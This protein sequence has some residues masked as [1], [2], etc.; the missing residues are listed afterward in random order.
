L[1][2]LEPAEA[3]AASDARFTKELSVKPGPTPPQ[4]EEFK[5]EP[6]QVERGSSHQLT[7]TSNVCARKTFGAAANVIDDPQGLKDKHGL[8]ITKPQVL[9]NGCKFAADL[10]VSDSAA[11]DSVIITLHYRE[12][13][14]DK[15]TTLTI[16]VV[17]QEPLPPGPIPPGLKPQV[18]IMWG[19][20][21]QRIVKDNFGTR[22]GKLFYCIEVVIGNNTGYDLQIASVG[23]NLGAVSAAAVNVKEALKDAANDKDMRKAIADAAAAEATASASDAEA[24]KKETIAEIK[25]N[26]CER[27]RNRRLRTTTPCEDADRAVSEAREARAKAD[28][29]RAFARTTRRNAE[30]QITDQLA[31][32]KDE[33]NRMVGL[34][35]IAYAQKVP[36]SSYLITRGSVV[37]GQI[38]STRNV[39]LNSIKA[40]G[41]VLTG[42]TPFFHNVNHRSNYSELVN[43]FSNP[44]E[45]GVEAVFPDETIDQLQRLDEEILRDGLIIANNRQTRTRV[46]IPKDVLGLDKDL[47]GHDMR[48]DPMMVTLALGEMYLIGNNISYINRVSVTSGSSGEITPRPVADTNYDKEFKLGDEQKL[49]KITG[50]FLGQ[51]TLTSDD[52]KN[53]KVTQT[54]NTNTTLT[55]TL[56]IADTTPLGTHVLNLTTPAGTVPLPIVVLQPIA[57]VDTPKPPL[58]MAIDPTRTTPHQVKITGRFLQG[59][60]LFPLDKED[61]TKNPLTSQNIKVA[62]DGRSLTADIMVPPK[63]P[64]G[65]YTFKVTNEQNKDVNADLPTI[66]VEVKPP[67]APTLTGKPDIKSGPIKVLTEAKTYTI[68]LHGQNL[69]N[70]NKVVAVK[71]PEP[72]D[73]VFTD[74]VVSES[75]I[76]LTMHVTVPANK[77]AG[78]YTFKLRDQYNE[79]EQSFTIEVSN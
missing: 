59:A 10:N 34:S 58:S 65:T 48:D 29:D 25:L 35:R 67:P 68:I 63:A 74:I 43:I 55:A 71:P 66:K 20:V 3:R 1:V 4:V 49:I 15:T 51:G 50:T 75:G 28:V 44:F 78:A 72:T 24:V 69:S 16:S 11:F 32:V 42:F 47:E 73:F 56:D 8:E 21:P 77:P 17:K 53:I 46:F 76:D 26:L 13:Q 41:P 22:V 52:P 27:A 70:V 37:H 9:E 38:W 2:Q 39:V 33:A 5:I 31:L 30:N 23:F 19:V 18:D 54:S 60:D 45:K 7:I 36:V 12:N 40:L 79:S 6:S 57:V 61:G 14:T 64:P 62:P